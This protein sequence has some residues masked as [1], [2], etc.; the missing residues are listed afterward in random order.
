[1]KRMFVVLTLIVSSLMLAASARATCNGPTCTA[2]EIVTA[3]C[4][5]L[6]GDHLYQ[7]PLYLAADC[8]IYCDPQMGPEFISTEQLS[9]EHFWLF[10]ERGGALSRVDGTFVNDGSCGKRIRLRFD[11][12]LEADTTYVL[13]VRD[14]FLP[15][16]TLAT[17]TTAPEDLFDDGV[18]CSIGAGRGGSFAPCVVLLLGLCLVL[19]RRR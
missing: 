1:M 12:T 7:V 18:G 5:A 9:G 2:T 10:M 8:E 16:F 15:G 14:E 3:D 6:E 13:E 4:K 17:F 19:R 11:G